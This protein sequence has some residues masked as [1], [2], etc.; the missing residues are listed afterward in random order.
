MAHMQRIR[1][2]L[3][4]VAAGAVLLP[5]SEASA[6]AG[7]AAVNPSSQPYETHELYFNMPAG[8]SWGSSSAVDI[9]PD[10]LHIWVGERCGVNTCRG[11]NLDPVLLFDQQGNLVRSFGAGLIQWPHGIHVDYD[12]N[13]WIT[14]GQLNF[15][16]QT[17][18]PP[19]DTIGMQV[20]K[21]SPT[22]ELLL[23]LGEPGGARDPGHFWQPND[24]LVAPDGHIFVA[25]GHGNAN[26]TAR[27]IKFTPDGE[28][29]LQWGLLGNGPRHLM[30]PHALAM[31]SQGRLFVGD[32]S[33]NRIQIYDQNGN[34]LDTW[35]QFSRPSGIYIDKNDVIYVADSESNSVNRDPARADWQRGIRIGSAR[36]GEVL[37]FIPDPQPECSGTC[38]AEGVVVDRNGVIYGAEVGP[39][40]GIKRYTLR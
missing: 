27:V 38:T 20:H 22:G 33:N 19:A 6:Q 18:P 7:M 14:D 31:D 1:T 9:A 10:G 37:H 23:S 8:R 12:G 4:T 2:L 5:A 17:T 32:R 28:Y 30:Q 3:M 35:Y 25:E 13:V 40:G 24:V 21:F 39:V 34:L 11:S 16:A 36:T 26:T 15:T 29:L